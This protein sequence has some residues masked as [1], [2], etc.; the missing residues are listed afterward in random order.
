[1]KLRKLTS[2][3][4]ALSMVLTAAVQVNAAGMSEYVRMNDGVSYSMTSP[5]FWINKYKSTAV[6]GDS[7]ERILHTPDEIATLNRLNAQTESV[8]DSSIS[9]YDIEGE[10]D[11]SFVRSIFEQIS[12]PSDPSS[13]FL[14]GKPTDQAYWDELIDNADMDN[15]PDTVE[16]KFGYSTAR[17]SLRAFPSY[18]FIGED[19]DDRFFDVMVYSEYMPFRP[20]VVVHESKDGNW[21]YVIF[22]GYSGWVNKRYVALCE[23]REDWVERMEP[24]DFLVVTGRE[25]RLQ[26]DVRAPS[27]SGQLIPMGTRLPLVKKKDIPRFINDRETTGCYVVKLPVRKADG[28]ITDKYSLISIKE[29]VNIG[30]LDYTSEN[31]IR[32]AMKR[33]GDRYGWAGVNFSNDCSG[34]AGEIFRC[35][36][37]KLP[38]GSGQ[39]AGYSNVNNVDVS[40][41]TAD[42]KREVLDDAAI[43]SLLW[44]K[45]HIMIYLGM[46]EG[47]PYCISATGTYVDG[48]ENMMDTNSVIITNMERTYRAN[49][50]TWLEDLGRVITV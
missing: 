1:M 50:E 4:L 33:L 28:Y 42:E 14:G 15:V 18:D 44:F 47:V 11:G 27:L 38:R 39:I 41:M 12:A 31:V 6:F 49:G 34:M 40:E 37:I 16:V 32:L 29:D 17:S 2:A 8:G 24:E 19:K 46:H 23:S 26:D 10:I 36:G 48:N 13:V 9:I 21:Y 45:G 25:L 30:Y 7:E 3:L 5:S 22:E 20:L 35:F 43:G